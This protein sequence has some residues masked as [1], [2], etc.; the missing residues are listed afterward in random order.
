MEIM[1]ELACPAH[2][3]HALDAEGVEILVLE[4]TERF[5]PGDLLPDREGA[6][7]TH[8]EQE[9]DYATQEFLLKEALARLY[10]DLEQNGRA[11]QC[12]N[13]RD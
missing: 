9:K 12:M 5:C 7:K 4:S 2:E 8:K 11:L 10:Y 1:R 6:P 13:R 3:V